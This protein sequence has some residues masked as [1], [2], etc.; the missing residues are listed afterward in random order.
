MNDEFIPCPVCG[1]KP[2]VTYYGINYAKVECKPLFRKPHRSV[3]VGYEQPSK[4]NAR[5]VEE[6]NKAANDAALPVW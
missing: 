4:L 3:F 1:R 5:A 2:K 6:W